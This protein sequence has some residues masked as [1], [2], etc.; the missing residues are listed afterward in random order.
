VK[1]IGNWSLE[2]NFDSCSEMMKHSATLLDYKFERKLNR[3][4]SL[5]KA[6]RYKNA[7]QRQIDNAGE[8]DAVSG[9]LRCWQ[10]YSAG[11]F[12]LG[13][14]PPYWHTPVLNDFYVALIPIV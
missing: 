9:I 2:R 12:L 13:W 14:N 11:D 3:A 1:F 10:C 6:N 7:A 8:R 5:L 4:L